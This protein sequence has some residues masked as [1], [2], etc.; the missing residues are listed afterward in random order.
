MKEIADKGY[1]LEGTVGMN[2]TESQTE[3]MLGKAAFITNGTWTENEMQDAPREDGFEF[4][5][6]PIPTESA[7]DVHYVFDSCEQ[8]SIPAAAKNPELAKE[9][10]RFLYSDES[11]SAFAE[12]SGALYATKSAREVAK[13]KLS[14]AIYNMYGI[15]EEANASSL[16]M[17]FAAAVSYTHLDLVLMDVQTF[18]NHDGLTAGNAIKKEHPATKVVIITSLID[19]K[20]LER[21][22]TGC[23]DS[24]WYKDHG[25]AEL[26][27]VIHRTLDGEHV[28]PDT[29][30]DV[31]MNWI[32]SG[33]ISPRQ[34]EMLR[35]YICGMSYSEIAKKMDCST[36]GVRWNF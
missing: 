31:E 6:A 20:I 29:T 19:P 24:L 13:D 12:A 7:D 28:F 3:M 2:H 18:H 4:A 27:D 25:E 8:F 9:F 35:L 22:K 1:L 34:L 33:E 32:T 26:R 15:Y 10:L 23:A 30:P 21:A 17:S 14:T 16:I 36:S 11:V 5:M